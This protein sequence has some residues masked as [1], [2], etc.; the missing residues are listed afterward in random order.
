VREIINKVRM[1]V[2]MSS[3]PDIKPSDLNLE[4]AE[5]DLSSITSLRDAKSIVE[6]KK[7]VEVLKFCNNNISKTARILGISRPSVYSLKKKYSI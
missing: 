2:L 7:L 1:A 3:S 6:K 5:V 4:T